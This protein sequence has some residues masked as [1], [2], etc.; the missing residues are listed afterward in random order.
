MRTLGDFGKS[1]IGCKIGGYRLW[2]NRKNENASEW[3][4]WGGDKA[5]AAYEST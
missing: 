3:R 4:G 2:K 5:T 1:I